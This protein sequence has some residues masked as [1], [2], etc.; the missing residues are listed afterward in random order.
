MTRADLLRLAG[1]AWR[2]WSG[3]PASWSPA[4]VSMNNVTTI[5]CATA[6]AG[7]GTS[8]AGWGDIDLR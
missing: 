4:S 3:A 6:Q 8:D 2:C 7:G 1:R 5:G